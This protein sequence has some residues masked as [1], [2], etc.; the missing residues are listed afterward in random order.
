MMKPE[1]ELASL[2]E[3][4]EAGSGQIAIIVS[5]YYKELCKNGIPQELAFDL[6]KTFHHMWWEKIVRGDKA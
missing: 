2:M 1:I 5:S 6:T 3:Q 4:F